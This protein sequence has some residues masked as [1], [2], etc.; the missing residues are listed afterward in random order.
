MQKLVFR[1]ANNVEID[2]T[3]GNFGITEWE[4]FS[5]VELNVQSQQVPFHDGSV[6]LDGLLGERE[7]NVTLAINDEKDLEKRY[8]LR[9]QLIETLNPKLGE[10][11]LIYTNDFISKQIK[12][13]SQLPV[14]ENHNANDSGTPKASLSW[15]A[16]QPYWEDLQETVVEIEINSRPEVVNN[17]DVPAQVEIDWNGEDI[18]NPWIKNITTGAFI[19]G[20]GTFNDGLI[21]DTNAGNK[22]AIGKDLQFNY[23]FGGYLIYTIDNR[24]ITLIVGRKIIL[25]G[26]DG[27]NWDLVYS[28]ADIDMLT[29]GVCYSEDKDLFV[30]CGEAVSNTTGIILTSKD[31]INW[32]LQEFENKYFHDITYFEDI[33]KFIV[34]GRNEFL[35][36]EDGFNWTSQANSFY[37]INSLIKA[38]GTYYAVSTSQNYESSIIKSSNF[39][40]WTSTTL[41]NNYEPGKIIYCKK[42]NIFLVLARNADVGL[43]LK[44]SDALNWE[45]VY[46]SDT[47]LIND[48]RWFE[49][50]ELF[51]AVGGIVKPGIILTS[52][53]AINWE[54]DTETAPITLYGINY[55][56]QLGQFLA[57]S[58]GL[59]MTSINA[60]DWNVNGG[61]V[62]NI[63]V[64]ICYSEK[65]DMYIATGEYG[66][67]G[68]SDDGIHWKFGYSGI[69]CDM[70]KIIYSEEKECFISVGEHS[71]IIKSTDGETWTEVNQYVSGG[72]AIDFR[73]VVYSKRRELFVAIGNHNGP[74]ILT[75]T[76]GETWTEVSTNLQYSVGCISY[77]ENEDLFVIESGTKIYKS[78]DLENWTLLYPIIDANAVSVGCSYSEDKKIFIF[79]YKSTYSSEF[80]M[81]HIVIID[82]INNIFRD[83]RT[84]PEHKNLSSITYSPTLKFFILTTSDGD[85]LRSIDGSEW[86]VENSN[87]KVA[88]YGGC[89]SIPHNRFMIVGEEGIILNSDFVEKDNVINRLSSDSDMNFNLQKGSNILS[90][91]YDSGTARAI[92]RYRQKYV[93]V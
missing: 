22:K 1:N 23:N 5:S 93:G 84:L 80:A 44:S 72:D 58:P 13:I 76:D 70:F 66:W 40:T 2:L 56:K 62:S 21:I 88:W 42:L 49:Q 29:G 34:C 6:Y 71:L 54:S 91:Y 14:F 69:E 90:I 36:S 8:E 86:I 33:G 41:P 57:V 4:G 30:I 74:H 47:N 26:T 7:L 77:S 73:D 27:V 35:L 43:I 68:I 67:M 3:S 82:T 10:G 48:I 9:R 16:C 53:D 89:F 83:V 19:R 32:E 65:L 81:G 12:V 87:I 38:N 28:N 78:D 17:G 50:F 85:I 61:N 63:Y 46:S 11:I 60:R 25:A 59:I 64:S 15:I 39:E 52:S 55:S 18:K 31:G 51:V 20:E 79:I 24:K 37:S 75:S 45:L 92:L